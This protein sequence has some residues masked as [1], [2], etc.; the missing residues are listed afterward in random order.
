MFTVSHGPESLTTLLILIGLPAST[1]T[2]DYAR[3]VH[4][5]PINEGSARAGDSSELNKRETLAKYLADTVCAPSA[6]GSRVLLRGGGG[7]R[8]ELGPGRRLGRFSQ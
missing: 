6:A 7:S 2:A 4:R 8:N 3:G 1:V 5:T